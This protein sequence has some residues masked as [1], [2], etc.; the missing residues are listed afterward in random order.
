MIYE[1]DR[2]EISDEIVENIN[3]VIEERNKKADIDNSLSIEE[4]KTKVDELTIQSTN[5]HAQIEAYKS[6]LKKHHQEMLF[7]KRSEY[8]FKC[9]KVKNNSNLYATSHPDIVAFRIIEVTNK[10]LYSLQFAKCLVLNESKKDFGI[11]QCELPLWKHPSMIREKGPK[12]I[13][14]FEEINYEEFKTM[15]EEWLNKLVSNGA[16]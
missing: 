8:V 11:N 4:M 9:Y 10:D 16:M 13:D 12:F 15:Y 6:M 7:D 2:V 1:D 5:I 14:F 3:K